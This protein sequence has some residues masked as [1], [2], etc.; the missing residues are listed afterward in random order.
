M[1]F[2]ASVVDVSAAAAGNVSI[3]KI[4]V[5]PLKRLVL[6]MTTINFS[7]DLTVGDFNRNEFGFYLTI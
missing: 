7:F 1:S 4:R 2:F 6:D 5:K 3:D